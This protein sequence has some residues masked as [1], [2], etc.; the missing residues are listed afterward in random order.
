MQFNAH[1]LSSVWAIAPEY[2]P[3]YRMAVARLLAGEQVVSDTDALI[4]RERSAPQF[5][6]SNNGS[7][8]LTGYV[9]GWTG[10]SLDMKMLDKLPKGSVAITSLTDAI[11][12]Y[13]QACGP[14]G[15]IFKTRLMNMAE[16]HPNIKAHILKI[17]SPGGS[18]MAMLNMADFVK[19]LKKPVV[20]FVDD[21]SASAAY[22]IATGASY[23]VANRK[24]AQIGSIGT[25]CT[26][27][28]DREAFEKKGIKL[29]DVYADA[30]TDKNGWYRAALEGDM[31]PL[32]TMLNEWNEKF[33]GVVETNRGPKLTADRKTWGTGKIYNADEALS[34]GLI[35]DI[36]SFNDTINSLLNS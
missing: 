28:D 34:L 36:G 29:T 18:A 30:S 16:N 11:M 10:E 20:A 12:K 32:K 7:Y 13:D 25:M 15:M 4:A 1:I 6:F 3:A 9:D 5:A 8:E 14:M 2:Q 26:M 21:L 31:A 22:G 19:G 35:D 27:V 23:I 33:L 17:D 24:E